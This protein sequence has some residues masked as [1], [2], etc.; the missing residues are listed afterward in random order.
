MKHSYSVRYSGGWPAFETCRRAW[1]AQME[2]DSFLPAWSQRKAMLWKV[3]FGHFSYNDDDID[4][5]W[6]FV[7]YPRYTH[8][9]SPEIVKDPWTNEED[10]VIVHSQSQIGNKWTEMWGT[11][12]FRCDIF[13]L[14]DFDG[15]QSN[16][17]SWKVRVFFLRF[18]FEGTV[19]EDDWIW[20][21]TG[22]AVKNR[23]NWMMHPKRENIFH[24]IVSRHKEL[25]QQI[26]QVW[27]VE[28][29]IENRV[30]H[31]ERWW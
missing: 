21:R 13:N 12:C 6:P 22:N 3:F 29:S 20:F 19:S 9:L 4:L 24:T 18:F 23:W 2:P 15:L 31:D 11:I 30:C 1:L 16:V 7:W 27:N 28:S 25:F 14:T 26:F 8:Q 5:E 17:A 10:L